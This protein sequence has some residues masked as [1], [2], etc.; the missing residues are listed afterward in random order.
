MS[1]VIRE[2]NAN[3]SAPLIGVVHAALVINDVLVK[4]M[5]EESFKQV[6]RPRLYHQ[7]L[8]MLPVF[9]LYRI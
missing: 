6:V 5:S 1:N 7:L 4:D 9:F 8:F 3:G 2:I